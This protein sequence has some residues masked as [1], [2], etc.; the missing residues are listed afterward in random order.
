MPNSGPRLALLSS[1]ARTTWGM[2]A[3]PA[4]SRADARLSA[5]CRVSSKR[6]YRA[7]D[8]L[9]MTIGAVPSTSCGRTRAK[10]AQPATATAAKAKP[11]MTERSCERIGSS[12]I[13][14]VP[15]QQGMFHPP[16]QK[17]MTADIE[18]SRQLPSH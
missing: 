3:V 6:T 18:S 5:G 12:T 11:A 17:A 14:N 16:N 4:I 15:S 1:E 13:R 2:A 9:T 8:S 10:I 7:P